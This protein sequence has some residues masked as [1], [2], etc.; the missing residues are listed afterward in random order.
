M[1]KTYRLEVDPWTAFEPVLHLCV[2]SFN[3]SY[4]DFSEPKRMSRNT[5]QNFAVLESKG[6]L[7]M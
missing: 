1:R 4:E 6:F 7:L 3:S 5:H 2:V